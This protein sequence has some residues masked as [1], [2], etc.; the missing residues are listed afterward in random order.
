MTR[1]TA[2]R[3]LSMLLVLLALVGLAA[4]LLPRLR[5]ARGQR[6]FFYVDDA[7]GLPEGTEVRFRGLVVGQVDGVSLDEA[8]SRATRMPWFR[9][10]FQA[11]GQGARVLDLWSFRHVA[12][13]KEIPMVGATVITLADPTMPG[14][15]TPVAE[16]LTVNGSEGETLP[17]PLREIAANIGELVLNANSAVQSLRGSLGAAP[18]GLGDDRHANLALSLQPD[19]Y[20]LTGPDSDETRPTRLAALLEDFQAMAAKFQ[21]AGENVAT[22]MG[23]DGSA[24]RAFRQ[25]DALGSNLQDESKPF[26]SVFED[27]KKTSAQLRLDIANADAL[28][29]RISPTI[30]Q[31]TK[32]AEEMLDTLKR[33]PWRVIWRSTKIYNDAAAPSPSPAARRSAARHGKATPAPSPET[34]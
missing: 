32:D 12:L 21:E 28:V 14:G 17:A 19:G 33:E 27:L 22:F 7:T 23:K 9:V 29:T 26:Q 24:D 10:E 18:A 5:P 11:N 31:S 34:R 16:A 8:K 25:M 6:Y 20:F 4:W 1:F 3:V 13:G 15:H 30:D 2:L